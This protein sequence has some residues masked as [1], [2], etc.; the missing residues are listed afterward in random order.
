M[1]A[2]FSILEVA[3]AWGQAPADQ[4]YQNLDD[5]RAQLVRVRREMD[6]FMKDVVGPYADAG[7][8]TAFGQDVRVDVTE[9]E[10]SVVVRADLPG[11]SK[12]KI[13]IT[14]ANNRMLRIAGSRDVMVKQEGPGVIRQERSSGRFERA[15]QLPVECES[16]GI[17]ATYK[18]GVLEIVLPKKKGA[19]E[20]TVKVKV[21]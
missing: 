13:D 15:L 6:K 3:A 5:L 7:G 14:L 20:D 9:N 12:D 16:Q 21:R 18:E 11:M 1:V 8:M 2:V 17:E 19:V 4:D 10:K